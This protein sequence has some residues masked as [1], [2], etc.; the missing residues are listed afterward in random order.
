MR[1]IIILAIVLAIYL[2]VQVQIDG[3][4]EEAF[5]KRGGF[6]GKRISQGGGGGGIV[7]IGGE[8]RVGLDNSNGTRVYSHSDAVAGAVGAVLGLVLGWVLYKY[9]Y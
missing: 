4:C 8:R 2:V 7:Y 5:G 1:L 9:V 3:K 6:G